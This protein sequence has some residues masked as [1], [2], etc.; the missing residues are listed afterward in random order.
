MKL[1]FY[2]YENFLHSYIESNNLCQTDRNYKSNLT[3]TILEN[4]SSSLNYKFTSL[5][6]IHK[7]R[8]NN[9]R[10]F[11]DI[12]HKDKITSR[13]YKSNLLYF[14]SYNPSTNISSYINLN[15]N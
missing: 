6:Q 1:K 4:P 12:F 11:I 2:G 13:N 3:S 7:K 8:R 15:R 5:R 14:T 10:F 9:F